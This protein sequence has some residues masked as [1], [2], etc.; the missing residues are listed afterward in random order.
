MSGDINWDYLHQKKIK[1]YPFIKMNK[2]GD[3]GYSGG[4]LDTQAGGLYNNIFA[5]FIS[6]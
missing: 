5:E 6:D 2:S 3:G 4:I 1:S